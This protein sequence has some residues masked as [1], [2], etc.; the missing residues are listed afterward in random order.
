MVD[1][2]RLNAVNEIKDVMIATRRA[3]TA[4]RAGDKLAGMRVIPLV[5]DEK[6]LD[7]A[8]EAAGDAPLLRCSQMK[9]SPL[10][11]VR[12]HSAS[13]ASS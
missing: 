3:F 10:S 1:V 4:V 7:R 6:V 13:T 11:A 2:D 9:R 12:R 8:K 5:I